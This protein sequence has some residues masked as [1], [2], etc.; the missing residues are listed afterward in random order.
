MLYEVITRLMEQLQNHNGQNSMLVLRPADADEATVA[1]KMAMENTHTPTGMIFS[2][3]NIAKLPAETGDRYA[4]ALQASK[5]AYVVLD[6]D[7]KPDVIV[8]TSYSIHYTKL[9]EAQ[10]V[11]EVRDLD[12]LLGSA[13]VETPEQRRLGDVV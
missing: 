4:E 5:G 2:R 12:L 13:R 10:A 6:C 3:Q 9:Y 7:G 11:R 8:I 1:W